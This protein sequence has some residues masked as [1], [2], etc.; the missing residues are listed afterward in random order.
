M[1]YGWHFEVMDS[2]Q[3]NNNNSKQQQQQQSESHSVIL[4]CHGQSTSELS[5]SG[6]V[7]YFG[8]QSRQTIPHTVGS[9][10]HKLNPQMLVR[11]VTSPPSIKIRILQVC[12]YQEVCIAPLCTDATSSNRHQD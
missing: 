7:K 9:K 6:S 8:Y 5:V 4:P 10:D 12:N 3:N 1:L 11:A 2:L